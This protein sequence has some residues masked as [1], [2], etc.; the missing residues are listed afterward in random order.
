VKRMVL[1]I[2]TLALP[3]LLPPGMLVDVV[4]VGLV[5]LG[6]NLEV[7]ERREWNV[8]PNGV[9]DENTVRWWMN[10][11]LERRKKP[12]WLRSRNA[13]SG[14]DMDR[15][16][17]EITLLYG[18]GD[19]RCREVW[20]KGVFDTDILAAH[21]GAVKRFLPWRYHEV[22]DLRTLMKACGVSGKLYDE[23][24]HEGLADALAE[25]EELR[26]CFALLARKGAA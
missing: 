18:V 8:Q 3:E 19:D 24:A 15:V 25:A 16:L 7:L 5:V 21:F 12:E 6:D 2:E 17:K 20:S 11:M 26:E 4:Q 13:G 10:M 14:M 23:V 1:D 9:S 22:R